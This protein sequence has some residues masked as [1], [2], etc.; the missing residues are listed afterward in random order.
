MLTWIN[1]LYLV[2]D[3]STL[4]S[5]RE[6]DEKKFWPSCLFFFLEFQGLSIGPYLVLPLMPRQHLLINC[7]WSWWM[8]AI[9][10]LLIL[11]IHL[12]LSSTGCQNYKHFPHIKHTRFNKCFWTAWQ[13]FNFGSL[14]GK[15]SNVSIVFLDCSNPMI[16]FPSGCVW[17]W[18][19]KEE[20]GFIWRDFPVS[21]QYYVLLFACLF[22]S[23]GKDGRAIK[24]MT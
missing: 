7:P 24:S 3:W 11:K 12:V 4:R 19:W 6:W 14:S 18:W 13:H 22:G 8:L 17:L 1:W 15:I 2:G 16:P 23:E 5:T 9:Q 20:K 21:F 10:W